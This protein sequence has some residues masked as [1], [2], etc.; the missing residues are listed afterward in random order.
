MRRLLAFLTSLMAVAA[1]VS[2]PANGSGHPHAGAPGAGDPYFPLDGNGGYDV[3]H[4]DLYLAYHP[5]TDLLVG[6]VRIVARA[7]QGLSSFNLDFDGMTAQSV[8]VSGQLAGSWHRSHGELTIEPSAPLARGASFVAVVRYSGR[9]ESSYYGGNETGFMHTG[10]G[11]LVAGEPHGAATWFPVNDHPSDKAS[12]TFHVRA[13]AALKVVANGRLRSSQRHGDWRTWVWDEH[14]PMASYLATIAIGRFAERTRWSDGVKYVDAVDADLAGPI[15]PHVGSQF[16][17]SQPATDASYKRLARVVRV[18]DGGGRLGLWVNRSTDAEYDFV[19]VEAHTVGKDDWTTLRDQNGHTTRDTGY[20]CPFWFQ[21][22]P[23]L[24]HYQSRTRGFCRPSG[25]TGGWWAATGTGE[26]WEHWSVDLSRFAGSS[27]HISITYVSAGSSPYPGM[28]VD[29]ITGPSGS[30]TT[31]FENDGDVMD[32]W[33][34]P[35]APRGSSAN[36]TDWIVGDRSDAPRTL[37]QTA[38]AA[39]EEEPEIV[40]FLAS[41]FGPYPFEDAGGIVDNEQGNANVSLETQTRPVY[42]MTFFTDLASGELVIVHEL[43]HQWFG[44]SVSLHR[45]RDI[46][47]NEGFATYAE[48]LW[49][50][51]QGLA[52]AQGI[53]AYYAH[54]GVHSGFWDGVVARPGVTYLF[55]HELAYI[56]GA[57]ALHALRLRIGDADF[58]RVLRSWS[59]QHAG[60]NGTTGDFER[61]AERICGHSLHR[62]FRDWLFTSGKPPIPDASR[63][64]RAPSARVQ[65]ALAASVRQQ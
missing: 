7:S 46:W 53:F 13:P 49:Y 5:S 45:W 23:F 18:P 9:P 50:K 26:G 61:L 19:F 42:G 59:R 1:L 15:V 55:S 58:F 31:S 28:V 36:A 11:A 65:H 52:T 43:A 40:Q 62:L 51:H 10:D 56:R 47:L 64:G 22:H 6:T 35:G 21:R 30:G 4:Y 17:I 34:V 38:F 60:A 12:Y 25:A 2:A 24:R 63:K 41:R 14:E 3:K 8:S 32:G 48:W 39:M 44:D 37:G 33:A 29:D 16:A 57:M 27:A 54:S 20:N